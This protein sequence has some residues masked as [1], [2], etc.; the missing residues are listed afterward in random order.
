MKATGII[1][2]IDDLGR[3]VIPKEIRK[4]LRIY[5][6][7]NIEIFI[8]NEEQIVLQKHSYINDI[9]TI[10]QK[11]TDSIYALIKDTIVITDMENIVAVTGKYKKDLINKK[12]SDDFIN[13]IRTNSSD[14]YKIVDSFDI[15]GYIKMSPITVNGDICG[16]L[17]IISD[18]EINKE[19]EQIMNVNVNFLNK[20]LE[21]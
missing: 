17:I 8:N 19:K 14:N 2:R 20:Y 9:R 11:I 6:G 18:N 4:K 10:S 16:S 15:S 12:I 3:I 13:N 5:E 21:D 1:R 7:D